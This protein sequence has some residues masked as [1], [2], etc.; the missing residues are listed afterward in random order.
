MRYPRF[1]AVFSLL[2]SLSFLSPSAAEAPTPPPMPDLSKDAVR[3]EVPFVPQEEPRDCGLACL[4]MISAYYGQKLNQPQVDWIHTNS[5]AGEGV[6]ASELVI[7]LGA[8]D[9][10]TA[11]FPGTLDRSSTGLYY[12]LEKKRPLIVMITSKDG[13]SSHYDIV[14]GYDPVKALVLLTDPAIGQIAVGRGQFEA[15]WKRANNLTLLAVPKRLLP[16]TPTPAPA[17]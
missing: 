11:L 7:V 2:L 3:L 15:A 5:K 4:K 16:P 12:H 14:S 9:F 1:V 13:K 6:M 8:A 17:K 10:E